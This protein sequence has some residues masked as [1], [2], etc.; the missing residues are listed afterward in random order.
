MWAH[1]RCPTA[2]GKANPEDG[3]TFRRA[4]SRA[5]VWAH[6]RCP[7]AV[8][9]VDEAG[10]GSMRLVFSASLRREAG[11]SFS[12]P[13]GYLGAWLLAFVFGDDEGREAKKAE[14]GLGVPQAAGPTLARAVPLPVRAQSPARAFGPFGQH[15]F[16]HSKS[17][18]FRSLQ[19]PV[20]R[21]RG[22]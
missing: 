10:S 15:S 5:A 13:R 2:V 18:A 22:H 3:P 4:G 7:T 11:G 14:R 1:P 21:A 6:P 9:K 19:E 12:R 17:A 16:V 20:K 8:G